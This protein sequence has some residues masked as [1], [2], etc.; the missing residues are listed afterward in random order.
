MKFKNAFL[1]VQIE[2]HRMLRRDH[3]DHRVR[4]IVIN[5][6]IYLHSDALMSNNIL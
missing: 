4:R 6:N 3:C 2:R 5:V 1:L